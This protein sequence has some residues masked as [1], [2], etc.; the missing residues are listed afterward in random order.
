MS[1]KILSVS[2]IA[3]MSASAMGEV[4]VSDYEDLTEG[5]LTNSF[6][7]TF[8]HNGVTYAEQNSVDGVFPDG[9]VFV[10]GGDGFD[11]LGDEIIVENAA[12]FYDEFPGFGSR[13]NALT[14]GRSFIPGDNLS[15]GPLSTVSM[16]L[17]TNADFASID[18]GYLE[19]GPWGGIVL[20]LEATL[21]GMVVDADTITLS[22]LGGRDSG[23][24]TT[25]MVDGGE[26]DSLQLFATLGDEF[27]APRVIIDN[28]TYNTI[29]A[30]GSMAILIGSAGLMTRRRR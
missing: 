15:L 17:D 18:V 4:I 7:R 24:I 3:L 28:L 27:T 16:F 23:A 25:L 2:M 14:F 1:M 22:N 13:N 8:H 26:F 11:S 21:N 19:N 9:K 5:F 20:H 6:N 30:P 12:F 29:P 10:A